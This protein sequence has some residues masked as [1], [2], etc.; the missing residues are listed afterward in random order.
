MT[1]VADRSDTGNAGDAPG[2]EWQQAG[3][4]ARPVQC[5]VGFRKR[6]LAPGVELDAGDARVRFL[7]SELATFFD[8]RT[9][10]LESAHDG[11]LYYLY[12]VSDSLPPAG[13][14]LL[15]GVP[16]DSIALLAASPKLL[17]PVVVLPPDAAAEFA[18]WFHS[19]S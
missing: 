17:T 6:R 8:G 3:V 1:L 14:Q 5:A 7:S 13:E 19:L 16:R 10:N 2:R 11:H 18:G 15:A 4:V 12:R 9:G